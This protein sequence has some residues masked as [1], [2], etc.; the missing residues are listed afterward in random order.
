MSAA[1]HSA[2]VRA[3]AAAML[4]PVWGVR[5]GLRVTAKLGFAIAA[6]A[7]AGCSSSAS[8]PSTGGSGNANAVVAVAVTSPSEKAVESGTTVIVRGTVDPPSAHV[9][10]QGRA[11]AVGDG[12]F[13]GEASLSGAETT[14][15]VIGSAPGF[16]PGSASV[17]VRRPAKQSARPSTRTAPATV[18]TGGGE[19]SVAPALTFYAP[20]GNVSCEIEE[21]AVRCSVASAGVTL[22][23]PAG[24]A[25]GLI[26]AGLEVTRGAGVA[27]G[28]GTTESSGSVICEIP[29]QSVPRGITCTDTNT[30]HGFEA[31]RDSDRRK[32]F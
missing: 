32:V 11:A 21:G 13:Q 7:L 19:A 8:P 18:A 4:A 2:A 24:A 27:A 16:V 15:D 17:T 31:S 3:F 29:P 9:E 22:E 1:G 14:I 20:T 6:V 28:Y 5:G 23:L 26:V 30:G 12:V 25:Q 10:V